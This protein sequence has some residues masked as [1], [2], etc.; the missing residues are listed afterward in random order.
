MYNIY[1]QKKSQNFVEIGQAISELLRKNHSGGGRISPPGFLGLRW[2]KTFI[3]TNTMF[4]SKISKITSP[5]TKIFIL[6]EVVKNQFFILV[7]FASGYE[8]WRCFVII[9]LIFYWGLYQKIIWMAVSCVQTKWFFSTGG[10]PHEI[11]TFLFVASVRFSVQ[12][13]IF[14]PCAIANLHILANPA[15]TLFKICLDVL[16]LEILKVV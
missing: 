7:Q 15:R 13:F 11:K 8:K 16:N 6:L 2:K 3:L 5:S 10:Q 1:F 14:G 9:L 12:T 4:I